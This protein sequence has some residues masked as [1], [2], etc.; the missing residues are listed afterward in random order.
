[1]IRA[2]ALAA[3]VSIGFATASRR[4]IRHVRER[5]GAAAGAVA[6]RHAALR[7]QHARRPARDLRRRRRGGL[8]HTGSVPVGLEPVAVAARTEHRGL[9]GEPPL[10]LASASST[11]APRPPRVVAHAARRRR[12]A[13]HRLRRPGR[14]PRLHH[15][16]RTAGRTAPATRS[17]PRRASAAP[18]SGC[19]TRPTSARRS[20]ARRSPSS[21]LFGDTPRA[22]AV[23]PRRQHG[24]RG[25]LPL[26]QPDDDALRG[27]RLQRRRGGRRRAPSAASTMPGRPAGAEHELPG[28]RRSP[29]SASSSSSTPRRTTGR[30]SSAATGTTPCASRCPTRTSS[31]STRTPARRRRPRSFADVGT[32]LFNMVGQPGERE[33]LRLATPRRA[34]RCASRAPARSPGTHGA[35]P[36]A[37]GAHHRARRRE[38]AAAPPEQAHRLR[39]RPDARRASRRRASRRRSAWR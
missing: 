35:R 1:M 19:S 10:R 38:R 4:I 12:A 13:R 14:Q 24:L 39:R 6:G 17:S 5:P 16:P 7:R 37:R 27:R 23:E 20:A 2:L 33:G 28:H 32:V 30:T 11:S 22:L 9:G 29:R 26:R 15:R 3:V 34:T 31:R 25:R 8:T 21:T 18:T 36:P